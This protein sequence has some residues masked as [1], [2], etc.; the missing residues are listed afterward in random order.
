MFAS[1]KSQSFLE[2]CETGSTDTAHIANKYVKGF[3]AIMNKGNSMSD[4]KRPHEEDGQI[5]EGSNG[6]SKKARSPSFLP[7][8]LR[9]SDTKR[10]QQE[11]GEIASGSNSERK[12]T[13]T[14][15]FLPPELQSSDMLTNNDIKDAKN[16]VINSYLDSCSDYVAYTEHHN[17][18]GGFQNNDAPHNVEDFFDL[19]GRP[20]ENKFWRNSEEIILND[21][22]DGLSTDYRV[23]CVFSNIMKTL[24]VFSQCRK[25]I[26]TKNKTLISNLKMLEHDV[27]VLTSNQNIKKRYQQ[28]I[29]AARTLVLAL[30]ISKLSCKVVINQISPVTCC[31]PKRVLME[32]CRFNAF[33]NVNNY[34][35]LDCWFTIPIKLIFM[36]TLD[37]K[38]YQDSESGNTTVASIELCSY[39]GPYFYECLEHIYEVCFEKLSNELHR[40]HEKKTQ[41]NMKQNAS[42]MRLKAG[43]NMSSLMHLNSSSYNTMG[44]GTISQTANS[45]EMIM[46]EFFND[47]GQLTRRDHIRIIGTSGRMN[48]ETAGLRYTGYDSNKQAITECDPEEEVDALFVSSFIRFRIH[49]RGNV[50][51]DVYTRNALRLESTDDADTS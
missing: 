16:A 11:D 44:R 20:T 27:C 25:T 39:F 36:G 23:K 48:S 31:L 2:N 28:I 26:V 45:D 1:D 15:S 43:S 47:L 21:G 51:M 8:E 5:S 30:D 38:H 49:K 12:T 3:D 41:R 7:P 40:Y 33:G 42:I 17:E 32:L 22:D 29:S 35:Y 37:T 4:K 46:D 10:R 9:S 14:P 24:I 13:R 34:G 19:C 6:E 50:H 18:T